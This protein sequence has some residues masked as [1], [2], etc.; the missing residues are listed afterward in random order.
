MSSYYKAS[1]LR[2]LEELRER[3]SKKLKFSARSLSSLVGFFMGLGD[4][5][6]E[7]VSS[8]ANRLAIAL[9]KLQIRMIEPMI[10]AAFWSLIAIVLVVI[11]SMLKVG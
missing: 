5:V 8:S 4:R 7:L 1:F 6:F 10:M 9:N 11:L 2:I 3:A